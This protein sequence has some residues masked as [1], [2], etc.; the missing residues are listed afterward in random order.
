MFNDKEMKL[1][2]L[3]LDREAKVGEIQNASIMIIKSLRARGFVVEMLNGISTA[4]PEKPKKDPGDIVF[5]FGK[6]TGK[7]I[8]EVPP[9]YLRWIH[10]W[11]DNGDEDLQKKFKWLRLAI[12][13]YWNQ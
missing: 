5:S 12:E 4:K 8:K 2:R 7:K 13:E 3:A 11:I 9:D 10:S 1:W 6:H